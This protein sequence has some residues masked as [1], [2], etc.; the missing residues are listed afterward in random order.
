MKIARREMMNLRA[1][2]ERGPLMRISS[3]ALPGLTQRPSPAEPRPK[4]AAHAATQIAVIISRESLSAIPVIGSGPCIELTAHVSA[5]PRCPSSAA[6]RQ[7]IK[8]GPAKGLDR[9]QVAPAFS[10]CARLISLG[11]AVMKMNGTR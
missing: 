3:P 10:A 2:V 9:K 8:V 6:P 4:N 7:F 5:S 1:F 11:K